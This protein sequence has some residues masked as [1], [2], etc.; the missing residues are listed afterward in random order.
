MDG[1][2]LSRRVM[3]AS[4]L[5]IVAAGLAEGFAVPEAA[6]ATNANIKLVTDFCNS[7]NDPDKAVTFLSPNASVRMV[8]DQPAVVGQAAV[9]SAFKGY[10]AHGETIS[11]K[12]LSSF[13]EGPVVVNKRID[14]MRTPG[15]P[16]QSFK[17]VGVFTV[18]DGKIKEWA[19]YLDT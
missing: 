10:F 7:W 17:V 15:K 5:G 1:M 4:G 13:A 6:A 2:H 3:V 9:A 14:T 12:I 11:V 19:D 18:K 8:E 16:D